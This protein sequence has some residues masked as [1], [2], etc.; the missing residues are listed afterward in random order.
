[1]EQSNFLYIRKLIDIVVSELA[2]GEKCDT[3][4]LAIA[5]SD[6]TIFIEN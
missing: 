2:K 1:M 4:S 5:L 6:L 3:E